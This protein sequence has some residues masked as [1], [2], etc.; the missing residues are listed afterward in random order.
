MPS[1]TP[2]GPGAGLP[3]AAAAAVP[4]AGLA[5]ADQAFDDVFRQLTGRLLT[6]SAEAGEALAETDCESCIEGEGGEADLVADVLPFGVVPVPVMLT[7]PAVVAP[8]PV[9]TGAG[10]HID[11]DVAGSAT[12]AAGAR[13]GDA[14][15]HTRRGVRTG[16][17]HAG[18]RAI[19]RRGGAD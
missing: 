3:V 7:L 5:A 14:A 13:R 15:G 11:G 12:A 6:T 19:Q 4:A 18:R 8:A 2:A 1:T 16:C 9:G 10:E 17:G